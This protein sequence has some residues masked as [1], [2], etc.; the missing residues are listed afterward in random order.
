MACV[1]S[2]LWPALIS[3]V[4]NVSLSGGSLGYWKAC[5]DFKRYCTLPYCGHVVVTKQCTSGY[6]SVLIAECRR[7]EVYRRLTSFDIFY[8]VKIHKDR[9]HQRPSKLFSHDGV[10]KWKHLPSYWPFVRGIHRSPVN[11]PHKGQ[12]RRALMLHL[13]CDWIN[14]W[15]TIVTLVIWDA[16]GLIT[17]SLFPIIQTLNYCHLSEHWF[18][19]V[20]L[21]AT[22]P[23]YVFAFHYLPYILPWCRFSATICIYKLLLKQIEY[24]SHDI[25]K[26]LISCTHSADKRNDLPDVDIAGQSW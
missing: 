1:K 4:V 17:T 25:S 9:I 23:H 14:G 2:V 3:N 6:L 10:I 11:F 26:T 21:Y 7:H 16:I 5:N 8:C 22:I 13:T 18:N 15:Q 24:Y 12:W 19:R 20:G